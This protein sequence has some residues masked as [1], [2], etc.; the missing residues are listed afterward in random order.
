MNV[1]EADKSGY[2]ES[3]EPLTDRACARCAHY[4]AGEAD[5]RGQH[6]CERPQLGFTH[7]RVIGANIPNVRDAYRERAF[8]P[9]EADDPCGPEGK[10]WSQSGF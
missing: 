7:D 8:G 3:G 1:A 6:L 4:R 9:L 10:F 2:R 5:V